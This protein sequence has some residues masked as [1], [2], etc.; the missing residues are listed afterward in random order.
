[1]RAYQ[2]ESRRFVRFHPIGLLVRPQ[3]P[4]RRYPVLVE[5]LACAFGRVDLDSFLVELVAGEKQIRLL[6]R[7]ARR[8]QH[9]MLRNPVSDGEHGLEQGLVE[10]VAYAAHLAGGCHVHS[11]YGVGVAQ[12]RERELRALDAHIFELERIN[13][14]RF[15]MLAEHAAGGKVYEINL[16]HLRYEG[17]AARRAQVAFDDLDVVVGRQELDVEGAG[18]MQFSRDGCGG[19]AYLGGRD[20]VDL[21]R[22]ELYRGVSRMHSRKLDMFGYRR[23]YDLAVVGDGVAFELLATLHERADHDRMF[24]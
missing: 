22:R 16:Q 9:R 11:E 19:L 20:S 12:A 10:I 14:H 21:L 17:E 18:D 23:G 5:I 24:L 3:R 7:I 2:L 4:V 6:D 13:L 8:N 15:G 1:M